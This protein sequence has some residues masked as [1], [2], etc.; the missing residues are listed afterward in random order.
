MSGGAVVLFG[1]W[2]QF[3]NIS[4]YAITAQKSQ[5]NVTCK[6]MLR[7]NGLETENSH[8][9]LDVKEIWVTLVWKNCLSICPIFQK[10]K[11][12]YTIENLI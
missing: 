1:G 10:S 7:F 9:K 8:S 5:V 3:P 2:L 6:Q 11:A 12:L 4:M